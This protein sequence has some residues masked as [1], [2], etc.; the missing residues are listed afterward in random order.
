MWIQNT[1]LEIIYI[2]CQGAVFLKCQVGPLNYTIVHQH[3]ELCIG[4]LIDIKRCIK[5]QDIHVILIHTNIIH[6]KKN[7]DQHM[8]FCSELHFNSQCMSSRF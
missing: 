5:P 4:R 3:V 7:V 8:Q 2:D 6:F 1:F